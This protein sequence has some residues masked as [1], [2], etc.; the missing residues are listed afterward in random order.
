[1]KITP[2]LIQTRLLAALVLSLAFLA[3]STQANAT[4]TLPT[5]QDIAFDRYVGR[6]YEISRLPMWFERNCVGDIT[7]TYALRSDERID[8][9]NRCRTQNGFISA[10]GIGEV[11]DPTRPGELRVRFAPD[12]LA[13]IPVVWG[14]Y[15]IIE[16]DKDYRWVMVGAPNRNYLW[17]LSRTPT[18][19]QTV[20]DRLK[21][22][23]AALGFAVESMINVVNSPD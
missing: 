14:D 16:L 11:P 7:A 23:A 3:G 4:D 1:M 18:L 8:V 21:H 2:R 22:H 15:W 19:D 9:V 17:I 10:Q 20:V 13:W 5:V 6:W 12:W